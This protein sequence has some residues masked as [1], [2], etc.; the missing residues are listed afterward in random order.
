MADFGITCI[1]I[2][3][4]KCDALDTNPNVYLSLLGY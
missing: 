1:R 3:A 4:F 2:S